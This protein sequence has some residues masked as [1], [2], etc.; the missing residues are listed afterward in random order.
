MTKRKPHHK[1]ALRSRWREFLADGSLASLGSEGRL[2]ALYVFERADWSTCEVRFSLRRA[3]EAMNAQF[4]TV[5]RGVSQL[6]RAGVL[7]V[8]EPGN[9]RSRTKYIV[10]LRARSVLTPSTQCAQARARSVLSPSTPCAQS[11]H[12]ACS[13]RARSVLGAST[14]G[15][16]YSVSLSGTSVSTSES[17][18]AETAGA[19]VGPARRLRPHRMLNTKTGDGSPVDEETKTTTAEE[20]RGK[21]SHDEPPG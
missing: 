16:H 13:E 14:G 19:G 2:V 17:I 11:E 12:V 8:L 10:P 1:A 5:R 20:P 18:S 9:G 7:E 3:A 15:A 6:L 21:E 4:T